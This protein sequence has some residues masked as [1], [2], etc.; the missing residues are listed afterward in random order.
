MCNGWL[1][2]DGTSSTWGTEMMD[3]NTTEIMTLDS[4]DYCFVNNSTV[5]R[6]SDNVQLTVFYDNDDFL[7]ALDGTEYLGIPKNVS[8]CKNDFCSPRFVIYSIQTTL[9][10]IILLLVVS[11]IALHLYYKELRTVFGIL[12]IVFCLNCIGFFILHGICLQQISI[13]T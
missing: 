5:R 3:C 10:C 12:V 6:Y 1:G 4:S 7:V 11:I 9:N 13:Y 8:Y 2:V